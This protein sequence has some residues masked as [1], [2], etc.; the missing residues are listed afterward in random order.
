M[1]SRRSVRK[2]PAIRNRCRP[3][4]GGGASDGRRTIACGDTSALHGR[5]IAPRLGSRS[6]ADAATK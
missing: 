5:K 2:F 3:L 4:R 1:P 6:A